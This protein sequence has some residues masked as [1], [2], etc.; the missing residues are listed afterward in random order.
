M[1][2]AD[3]VAVVMA[4]EDTGEDLAEVDFIAEVLEDILLD[5]LVDAALVVG[6]KEEA[7]TGE[8]VAI[9]RTDDTPIPTTV[10]G[11]CL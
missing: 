8:D 3:T 7:V 10:F 5:S 9:T 6:G 1:E 11:D 2:G 4:V